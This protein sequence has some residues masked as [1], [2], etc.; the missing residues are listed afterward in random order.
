MDKL[1][2]AYVNRPAIGRSPGCSAV[3]VTRNIGYHHHQFD[4]GNI[5]IKSLFKFIYYHLPYYCYV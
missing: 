2:R 5:L 1:V 3:S 4:I